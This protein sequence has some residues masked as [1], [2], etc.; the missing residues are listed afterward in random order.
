M[1]EG[2]GDVRVNGMYDHDGE[3]N[4]APLFKK[5]PW[6][7]YRHMM[8]GG[9]EFWYISNKDTIDVDAGGFYRRRMS[10][11]ADLHWSKARD[12][13]LPPPTVTQVPTKYKVS[14]AGSPDANGEYVLDGLF[15]DAP[16]YKNGKWLL[17]RYVLPSGL[18]WWYISEDVTVDSDA[19]DLYRV[20]GESMLPPNNIGWTL[21]QDGVS[22]SPTVVVMDEEVEKLPLPK[23]ST[24]HR[25]LFYR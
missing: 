10:P 6:W 25:L 9:E 19:G 4:G 14:G 16:L 20:Q 1:V 13:T 21:A 17:N 7:M 22:P 23:K 15:Q 11:T 12:G 24:T 8:P 18:P 2:A 5:D 3:L